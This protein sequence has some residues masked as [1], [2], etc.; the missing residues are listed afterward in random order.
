V[1]FTRAIDCLH[2]RG[3]EPGSPAGRYKI[4]A[5]VDLFILA[6]IFVGSQNDDIKAFTK[7]H[8]RKALKIED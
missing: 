1:L 4:V 5:V 2:G 6:S 7:I 8:G 3:P